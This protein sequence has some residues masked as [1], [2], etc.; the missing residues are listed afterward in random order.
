MDLS[1][2]YEASVSEINVT[3]YFAHIKRDT[4]VTFVNYK[5]VR[6]PS[7][8]EFK[9]GD[10]LIFYENKYYLITEAMKIEI[11]EGYYDTFDSLRTAMYS[12]ICEVYQ[13][14][15][16]KFPSFENYSG[17]SDGKFSNLTNYFTY[18]VEKEKSEFYYGQTSNYTLFRVLCLRLKC[19][20]NQIH[21]DFTNDSDMKD[22]YIIQRMIMDDE[23]A[24]ELNVIKDNVINAGC[25]NIMKYKPSPQP[26]INEIS[27]AND[28]NKD[29]RPLTIYFEEFSKTLQ[30]IPVDKNYFKVEKNQFDTIFFQILYPDELKLL[31]T[32]KFHLRPTLNN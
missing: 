32:V 6:R 15:N 14:E 10:N 31:F 11:P 1:L 26:L 9:L 28:L 22:D 2:P 21:F 23:L 19:F 8:L 30:Y 20:S 4:Y 29:E 17:E 18:M 5:Q 12:R 16:K 7:Q 24:S 27:F 25:L 3:K 13:N